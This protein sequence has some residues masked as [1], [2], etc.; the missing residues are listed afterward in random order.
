MR[1]I[2]HTPGE[3]IEIPAILPPLTLWEK[4]SLVARACSYIRKDGTNQ[5]HKYNYA[6]AAQVYEKVNDALADAG[7][8]SV[9]QMEVHSLD[10]R[11][12][13]K[14]SQE[15]LATVKCTVQVIDVDSGESVSTTA[16]GSG[17][18]NGDKAIMKAQTAAMKYAWMDLLNISTGDDP[19]A[20]HTVDSRTTGE[21]MPKAPARGNKTG[22]FT[23]ADKE[24]ER[25]AEAD[26]MRRDTQA[27]DAAD[28]C[29]LCGSR[30]GS[31]TS[32]QGKAYRQCQMAHD[33]WEVAKASGLAS[34]ELKKVTKG[35]TYK[36]GVAAAETGRV[37]SPVEAPTPVVAPPVK[38]GNGAVDDRNVG[39]GASVRLEPA[40]VEAH[41]APREKVPET[42]EDVRNRIVREIEADTSLTSAQKIEKMS[43]T[44]S[45]ALAEFRAE[46]GI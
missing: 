21:K 10:L 15:T 41:V 8:V 26:R 32:K 35:H 37:D 28:I 20:D 1:E 14:G 34:E 29:N 31:Y 33:S 7:L 11:A 18:D 4:L 19:E 42:W 40:P 39:A 46:R 17:M 25:Q 3:P 2:T 16:Y 44:V 9:P 12:N 45:K 5:F 30:L 38:E 24:L 22:D 23:A 6:T 43:T 27:G 13:A 36:L